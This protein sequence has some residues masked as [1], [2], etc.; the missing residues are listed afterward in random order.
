MITRIELTSYKGFDKLDLDLG[1]YQVIVGP[2]G[3][4]K[5][6]LLD[7]PA[8]LS[9]MLLN[10]K[11]SQSAFL[12][13]REGAS[14]RA[15]SLDELIYKG[16]GDWFSICV[17]FQLPPSIASLVEV[18]R[19]GIKGIKGVPRDF[20]RYEIRFRVNG[21]LGLEI[22]N[23]YLILFPKVTAPPREPKSLGYR[24]IYGE[25]EPEK[26]WHMSLSRSD[27]S[28]VAWK[29]EAIKRAGTTR[30]EIVY[31]P[32]N[33]SLLALAGIQFQDKDAFPAARWVFE[34]LTSRVLFLN[35]DWDKVRKECLPG[36]AGTLLPSARNAV[37]IAK[38]LLD[39]N[40]DLYDRWTDHVKLAI[41]QIDTIEIREN[42]SNK[43]LFFW[44][45]YQSNF[46]IPSSGLSD[47][48]LRVMVFSLLAFMNNPPGLIVCEEPENGIHPKAV[49]VV[50]EALKFVN[51]S[52]VWVSTH[53]PVVV[54]AT[55]L[56]H[57]L[58]AENDDVRG[59]RIGHAADHPM[60]QSWKNDRTPNL[61]TLYATGVLG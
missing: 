51:G 37:W 34:F 58:T 25:I 28:D 5:T 7:V 32:A 41:P 9:D 21:S 42:P 1:Q 6:T 22:L 4:G 57:M 59:I 10:P 18:P 8:L 11:S 53:S 19:S 40:K 33:Q 55:D 24:R 26:S 52:Q 54:A 50:L 27:R 44:V 56:D 48:T 45:R 15:S 12:D 36:E 35:P 3:A 30:K 43:A 49:D 14:S 2:N 38:D 31:H 46:A 29:P 20:A 17:E 61:A 23:E 47:G 39:T 13:A 60:L 16:K